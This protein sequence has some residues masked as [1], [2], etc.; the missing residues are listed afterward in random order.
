M[1]LD[2]KLDA[3][4]VVEQPVP[5]GWTVFVYIMTGKADFGMLLLLRLLSV[6]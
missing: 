6:F 1:Y 3:G 4:A 5:Q 2:F